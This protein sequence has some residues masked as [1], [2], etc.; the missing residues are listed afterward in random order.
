LFRVEPLINLHR[1]LHPLF[2][3]GEIRLKRSELYLGLR[4]K[5]RPNKHVSYIEDRAVKL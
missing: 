2:Q 1:F 3:M 5:M 4:L